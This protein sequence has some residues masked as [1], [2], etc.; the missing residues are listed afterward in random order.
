[1][2]VE[3]EALDAARDAAWA[4]LLEAFQA[5][6]AC[7]GRL[8]DSALAVALAALALNRGGRGVPARRGLDWLAAHQNA[9]GGWGDTTDS[10]SNLATTLLT[11]CA[12][13]VSGGPPETVQRAQEWIAAR[14]GGLEAAQITQAVAA[15]YGAD[16]TFSAPILSV[17]AASGLLGPEPEAWKGV[18]P[19][20]F[21]AAC[22][23]HR[24]YK[25]VQLPVVSYAL[26]A[27]I[28]IGLARH[29]KYP[30]AFPPLRALRTCCAAP[31]LRVLRRMQ[32]ASGGFLEAVPLTAFVALNLMAAGE[33]N[34][35]A[36]PAC[37]DFLEHGQRPDG[38]WPIDTNLNTWTTS[39]AMRALGA[40]CPDTWREQ[41]RRY[42]LDSQQRGLHPFTHAAPG[43][44]GWTNLSG[45][46]PDADDTSAA[47]LALRTLGDGP[48]L[49]AAGQAGVA[50]L[51]SLQNRD[52]GMPTFC[53]GW[54]KLPFDR[55]CPDITAHALSAFAAWRPALPQLASPLKR[56]TRRALDYLA[57]AQNP[58][59][60]W[61]PLWFGNQAAPHQENPVFGTARVLEGLNALQ[62]PAAA[63]LISSGAAWLI[64]A[65][66]PD[67]GWGGAPGVSSSVE[68]T[69]LA[70]SAL[71][72]HA[73]EAVLARG[74]QFLLER[75][76]HGTMFPATPMGLY[77]S[78]LWYS[79]ALY[80]LIFTVH[81]LER[82]AATR[83]RH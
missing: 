82:M 62:D 2:N 24:V 69:A 50:W 68:E 42:L 71:A 43:G 18:M 25:W 15:F 60:S 47:L 63:P 10:P 76:Q 39:L 19:L 22:L 75:T 66:N 17:C 3:Y 81:A 36:L 48:E 83:L 26:P 20:P 30:A 38:A 49:Q 37:L 28:A 9:D 45:A 21:E 1:M 58:G 13:R 56:A 4:R 16:R 7:T 46:V 53:R 6:G 54:T 74:L 27:L 35:P 8:S 79:E 57:R 41:V 14:A 61:A 51:L 59:G 55:S 29:R 77:F 72:G 12:L 64:R 23:P 40:S 80:P 33:D 34:S 70:L 5:D 73:G 31:A 65:Q 44:W 67:G 32:P 11:L 52:G 78:S